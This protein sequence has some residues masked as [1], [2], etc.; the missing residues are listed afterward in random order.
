MSSDVDASGSTCAAPAPSGSCA[1]VG[2]L[3]FLPKRAR[4]RLLSASV[5]EDAVT[6]WSMNFFE[7]MVCSSGPKLKYS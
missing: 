1:V 4:T 6:S 3:F 2:G 7:L 5:I